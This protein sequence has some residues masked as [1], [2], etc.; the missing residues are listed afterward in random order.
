MTPQDD[1]WVSADLVHSWHPFTDQE[2][3]EG[4]EPVVIQRGKG[5]WLFDTKGRR[6]LDANSSI[7]TN[8]HGHSHPTIVSAIQKQAAALCHSSYLGLANDKASELAQ[9]LCGFF[10][11]ILT[12]CFFSDDGSTALEVAF[13][14]SLQWRQQNGNPERTGII[15]F[16]NAYHGDTLG[17]ASVGGVSRFIK[18]YGESGLQVYRVGTLADLQFLP[19]VVIETASAIVIEPIVQGVNQ[20]RLWPIGMLAEL[21]TWSSQND[22]HLILDEVMTGFGRT[23][24][25][26]ACQKEDVTPDFLCLAKGLTGGTMPLAATLTTGGIY[27]GFKG[28]GRTFYYGH[29]YTGNALGCA[30]ALASLSLFETEN[31]LEEVE[32]KGHFLEASLRNLPGILEIRRVGLVLGF[33]IEG[34]GQTFCRDLREKGVLTRPILNTVVLMPPLS[35]NDEELGFLINA[36]ASILKR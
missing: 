17:A 5:A 36:V 32:R 1:K 14:M 7:W 19:E 16:E 13:K 10:P 28:P 20:M 21:R 11:G 8:I 4:E 31:T 3:W 6:Y 12:R 33:D 15:A 24:A 34:C 35:I 30:A 27:E 2:L 26:F 9:K 23:G 22:I 18:G 29:S 25:M